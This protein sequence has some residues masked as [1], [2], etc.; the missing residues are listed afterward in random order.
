MGNRTM[1]LVSVNV[2]MPRE[3][4]HRGRSVLTANF[5][6]AVTGRVRP[7]TAN[8]AGDGQAVSPGSML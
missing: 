4:E 2:G 7:G 1:R 6:E 5:K 8:L 3:V